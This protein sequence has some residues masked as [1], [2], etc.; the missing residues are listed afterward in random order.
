MR[1]RTHTR[2]GRT[3][4]GGETSSVSSP[5]PTAGQRPAEETGAARTYSCGISSNVSRSHFRVSDVSRRLHGVV[6]PAAPP[7]HTPSG[8]TPRA[9]SLR[10]HPTCCGVVPCPGELS[11]VLARCSGSTALMPPVGTA[12]RAPD[13]LACGSSTR[14]QGGGTCPACPESRA[15]RAHSGWIAYACAYGS[16][17]PRPRRSAQTVRGRRRQHPPPLLPGRLRTH[18]THP[19][20]RRRE[21]PAPRRDAPRRPGAPPAGKGCSAPVSPNRLLGAGPDRPQAGSCSTHHVIAV[22]RDGKG[23]AIPSYRDARSVL[24]AQPIIRSGRIGR[25]M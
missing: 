17:H 9:V 23:S 22:Q 15:H 1:A 7:A 18:G 25:Q 24:L 8:R 3:G 4:E 19:A 14:L 16:S 10:S 2:R 12:R 20:S 21:Q 6:S 11:Q 5:C 13:A